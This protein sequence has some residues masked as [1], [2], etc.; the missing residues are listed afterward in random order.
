MPPLGWHA[1]EIAGAVAPRKGAGDVR[2]FLIDTAPLKAGF[3][4]KGA[5]QLAADGVHPGLYGNAMLGA[6]IAAEAQ[7]A[8]CRD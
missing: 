1:E 3:G 2:V 5:T 7:K 8:L 4:T 6:L